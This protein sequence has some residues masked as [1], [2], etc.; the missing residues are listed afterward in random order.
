MRR[1]IL[2]VEDN[3]TLTAPLEIALQS[4]PNIDVQVTSCADEALQ[5]F[6]GSNGVIAALVTDLQLP[7]MDGFTLI[8][9]IR[10]IP[11]YAALPIIVVTGDSDPLT[12]GRLRDLGVTALFSKPYSPNEMCRLLE[13]ILHET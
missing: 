4:L 12:P 11:G 2:I 13:E 1:K 6:S 7:R 9:H 10:S 3:D 8:Q 5:I